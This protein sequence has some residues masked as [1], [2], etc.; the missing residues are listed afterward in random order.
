MTRSFAGT[1]S[2]VLLSVTASTLHAQTPAA[3]PAAYLTFDEAAGTTAADASGN[4]HAATLFGA[5][6]WTPGQVGRSGLSVPGTAGSYA[7]IPTPVVDTTKSF[8]V[9]A[10]V[11]VNQVGG[12]Q[13]FVSEDGDVLSSFF[14]Q[15]RG[16]TNQFSFT[17]PYDFFVLAQS[18][19]TPT[20]GKWYHLAGVYD[21]AA[22]TASLFV[23]GVLADTVH[24]VV[25]GP[26]TGPTGIGRGKFAGNRVDFANA[27][28]DDVRLFQ[29][30][31]KPADILQVA[32][33][34]DPTLT[35]P[36]PVAPA[37][38]QI[39]AGHPGHAVSPT[40]HGLMIEEIN[41]GL[42][43]GLYGELIQNRV[44]KDDATAP[45]HWAA[46]QDGG[47]IGTI[48]LD[49]TQ[50]VAGTA[51][52][53]S[54]RVTASSATGR[55]GAA[56]DG[57]WGIPVQPHAGYRARFFAR[58]DAG[59][60]GRL[61]ASIESPDGKV[62]YAR[63]TV[64]R[65]T[66]QWAQYSVELRT[67]RVPATAN[68]RFVISTHDAGTFWLDQVSLF[69]QTFRNRPN[70]NR[71][72]LMQMMAGLTPSFLRLPGG[73]ALEGNT[74][75]ERFQW[76]TTI[77]PLAARPGHQT[78]WGYRSSDGLGLLE[79]LEWCEDLGMMPVL[80]V[81]AGYSLNGSF[82]APG[83]ALAPFVQ[84]ALDEIEYV[85]GGTD[86]VWGARRAADG[87]PAAFPLE[88]VE[89]GN[90]DFFDGSGSY[91]GRFA[92]FFDAIRA[93][94]PEL[95]VIATTGVTGRTPDVIDE[96]FY[97]T[98]R[99]FQRMATRYDSFDRSGPKIFVGEYAAIEGR[100]T[101]DLNAALGDAAWLTGLE[102]NS[103]LVVMV[104]Y[105]P[106]FVNINPGA[107]QWPNNLIGYDALHAYG[108]PSYHMQ[109]MFARL[110]GD[111][112]LPA[113]LTTAGGSQ[114]FESVTQDSW[115]GTMFLKLVNGA[116]S[117][118]RLHVSTTG[119]HNLASRARATI[120]TST[121]P[122]DTNTLSDPDHVV[123]TT[124]TITGIGHAFDVTLA[125]YSITVLEIETR[126]R[127]HGRDR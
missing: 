30:T 21:A 8:T 44:F 123:P 125:P 96:H 85:T 77:G 124:R 12:Y 66:S 70:G 68:A 27:A 45:V 36:L 56:N 110:A 103:D 20:P 35:G 51:L 88:Y 72:D 17:V 37:S 48:A 59:F 57:F 55:V 22:Q 111:V 73:N 39:D 43:G 42:D 95:K 71:V 91:S 100:P 41:H 94:H 75:D 105:A 65:L 13:T 90:E 89:V 122:Q 86:T 28:I 80:G 19:F 9:A 114:L 127:D 38:L 108:S 93:A 25:A 116:G 118:Q 58:A 11:K 14:L 15:L 83:P 87:H 99:A 4:G 126:D 79:Y 106:L 31:L 40:F 2:L 26:A 62:V 54:L 49:T 6:G 32:R 115:T 63:S 113:T 76:K 97:T 112:V 117:P 119:A 52:T 16:D 33:V 104:A 92:Q 81:Y 61:T 53:T 34:G 101:P 24:N 121:S 74:I 46:V 69:P 64:P 107:S 102:R 10:W 50:P 98:P 29:T 84:D 7:E 3:G 120:L 5:A 47:A 1:L 109:A 60:A 82:V 23:N 78:P 67:D 18:G